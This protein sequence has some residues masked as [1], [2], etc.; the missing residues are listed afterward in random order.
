MFYFPYIFFRHDL[1]AKL[2]VSI[3]LGKVDDDKV[4]VQDPAF[5]LTAVIGRIFLFAYGICTNLVAINMLI[6]MMNNSYERIMVRSRKHLVVNFG[7]G[8]ISLTMDRPPFSTRGLGHYPASS[9]AGAI[10]GRDF[11][12][13]DKKN[14]H[15]GPR[16]HH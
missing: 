4:T 9:V 14:K 2:L 15:L 11:N 13:K 5:D 3:F 12:P 8:K 7:R 10:E 6:A 16:L 1:A